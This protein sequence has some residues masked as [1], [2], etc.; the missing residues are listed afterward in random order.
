M[1]ADALRDDNDAVGPVLS[2]LYLRCG[3]APRPTGAQWRLLSILYLR[4]L[5]PARF[6]AQPGVA[7][8]FN[9]L[10]EMP[11]GGYPT[12]AFSLLTFNSLFEMPW[13]RPSY[14]WAACRGKYF[15]FSI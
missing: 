9:S 4:C 7:R 11:L 12:D 3:E 1:P 6:G 15:Q 2:I 14:A 13:W 5:C 10:F 8:S